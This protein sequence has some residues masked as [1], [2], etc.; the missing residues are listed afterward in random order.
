MPP[1]KK[2]VESVVP[3]E[4]KNNAGCIGSVDEKPIGRLSF[5]KEDE[6]PLQ[7]YRAAYDEM[8]AHEA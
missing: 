3:E 2:K 8:K 4:A 5:D 1:D 7:E 6:E